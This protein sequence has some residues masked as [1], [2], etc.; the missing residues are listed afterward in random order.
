MSRRTDTRPVVLFFVSGLTTGGAERHTI[1]LRARLRRKGWRTRV[2]AYG[3]RQSEAILTMEGAD[4]VVQ[5]GI[6]GMPRLRGWVAAWRALRRERAAVVV[7][8]NQ[9]PL[10]V[11]VALRLA[12]A[13]RAP[14]V[15][16]FHTTVLQKSDERK[17]FLYR[18]ALRLAD[19]LVYVSKNQRRYW[20]A[21]RLRC[22]RTCTILNGID[23]AWFR[24]DPLDRPALRA[25]LGFSE[26]D[27]VIGCVAVLRPE[28]NHLQLL[29]AVAVLRARGIRACALLIGDGP[30][31]DEI[32]AVARRLSV[33]QHIVLAGEHA[34]VRPLVVSCDVGALCSCAVETFSL[35]ALEF[36]AMGVPMV[37]SDIGGASEIVTHGVNGYVFPCGDTDALVAALTALA[38]AELRAAMAGVARVSVEALTVERMVDAYA[39][40][41]EGFLPRSPDAT[42]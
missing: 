26:A 21:R 11:A 20:S 14:I 19:T 42:A 12:G 40:L 34:D 32:V 10:I 1:D 27:F 33:D 2:I 6:V 31:R 39:G 38:D 18:A 28:K 29:A 36:L 17:F 37:M 7:A 13:F 22:R 23:L 24:S 3:A 5:L 25:S 4:D 9:T 16:V 41:L 8:V 30:M 15:G 35:A